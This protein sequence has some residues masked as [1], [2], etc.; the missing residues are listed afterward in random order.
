MKNIELERTENVATIKVVRPEKHNALTV[1]M[2]KGLR[3]ALKTVGADGSIRVVVLR[4]AGGRAFCVGADIGEF[5]QTRAGKP[6]A[7]ALAEVVH[8]C[9]RAIQASPNPTTPS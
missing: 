7:I 1:E 9:V 4:G 8:D 3:T 2:W 5:E 6:Q